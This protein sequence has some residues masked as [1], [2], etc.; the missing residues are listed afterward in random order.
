MLQIASVN[1]EG[2]FNNSFE[3]PIQKKKPTKL[4]FAIHINF[5]DKYENLSQ[6]L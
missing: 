4:W 2:V 3:E 6:I 1:I 5:G